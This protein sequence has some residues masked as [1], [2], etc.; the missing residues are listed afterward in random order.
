MNPKSS[1]DDI[2]R[3]QILVP[4]DLM[5]I[6]IPMDLQLMLLQCNMEFRL[7]LEGETT[8]VQTW[9]KMTKQL[10]CTGVDDVNH[11]LAM[12]KF[13]KKAE[14][15]TPFEEWVGLVNVSLNRAN[16]AGEMIA[17]VPQSTMAMAKPYHKQLEV[18]R[19]NLAYF[20][21]YE[22]DDQSTKAILVEMAIRVIS[23]LNGILTDHLRGDISGT[24]IKNLEKY[25]TPK[26]CFDKMIN[27][28]SFPIQ[29]YDVRSFF[30]P[31]N[32]ANGLK[33]SLKELRNK[34][35]MNIFDEL[36]MSNRELKLLCQ[37]DDVVKALKPQGVAVDLNE[38][39]FMTPPFKMWDTALKAANEPQFK[40][41]KTVLDAKRGLQGIS[42][43]SVTRLN[44]WYATPPVLGDPYKMFY[45]HYEDEL[46]DI[47]LDPTSIG[48]AKEL[49]KT[50][51]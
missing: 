51:L 19:A 21:S 35:I 12:R 33:F 37:S 27:K 14:G 11:F 43:F 5:R 49:S 9:D 40:G 46:M 28:I 2:N 34:E 15:E 17:E 29:N 42:R 30:F 3:P 26:W 23:T 36:S 13:I 18:A 31:P 1:N 45:K 38:Q 16:K 41:F 7:A 8:Q 44:L 32:I 47:S 4:N 24:L 10:V 48:L 6:R 39:V 50:M 20:K 25:S 22:T